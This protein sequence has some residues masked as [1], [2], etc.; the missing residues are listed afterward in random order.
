MS[1]KQLTQEQRYAIYVLLKTGISKRETA[2]TIHVS[3][4]TVYRELQRNAG[5]RGYR[6]K[7]AQRL[8]EHRR[9][10]SK[11]IR[12]TA[13]VQNLVVTYLQVDWSPEQISAVLK[14]DHHI[15]ISPERIYQ[16]IWADKH[17]GGSYYKHLRQSQKKK[18]KRYNSK[19]SRGQIKDRISIKERPTIV[20]N[21]ERIGDWEA[22]TVIGKNHKGALVTLVER[23]TKFT[24]I[25]YV[26][27][28]SAELVANAIIEMLTPYKNRVY[29]ITNDNGKEFAQHKRIAERLEANVYFATP[30]HSW[31]RGLNENTNGLIRQYFPKNKAFGDINEKGICFVEKKLNQRPRKTLGFKT[32]EQCFFNNQTV[33]LNN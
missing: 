28:K 6:Y 19:D 20:D 7:Q 15:R 32:P 11:N 13:E 25:M 12:F 22:D 8:A 27:N 9:H 1:Y 5:Q 4:S 29:T 23:K 26:P 24:T 18:R 3:R 2:E 31:E 30:Y 33:A 14:R 16:F 10:Q 21:K 17:A